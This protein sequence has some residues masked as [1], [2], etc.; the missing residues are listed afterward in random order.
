MSRLLASILMRSS[1]LV[2]SRS[3]MVLVDGFSLGKVADRSCVHSMYSLDTRVSQKD[4][5][6]A[7][8]WNSGTVFLGLLKISSFAAVHIP[9]GYYSNHSSA[10]TKGE[11][12]ME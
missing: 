9:G 11:R 10:G 2:D 8:D 4:H 7:A 12:D 6:S 3:K 5:C 1:R